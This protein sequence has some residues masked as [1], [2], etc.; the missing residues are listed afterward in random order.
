M[1]AAGNELHIALLNPSSTPVV[2]DLTF[3]TPAGAVHPI[4]YQGIVLPAG[5]MTTVSV[6]SEVQNV[7]NMSVIA[8]TRTGR[9]VASEV[10]EIVGT[11]GTSRGLSLVPGVPSPQSHWAIPQAQETP[12][13][14][15]EVAIFNP[16]S[17]TETVEG[18]RL[19]LGGRGGGMGG[20]LLH[21]LGEAE[22]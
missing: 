14:S 7:A 19:I 11:G 21:L 6:A 15:S 2:V 22:I 18:I 20:P 17:A 12:G 5:Q 16:G 13:G 1:P 4:N 9:V 10:Q 8:A 3:M